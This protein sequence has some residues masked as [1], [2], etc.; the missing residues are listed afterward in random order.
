MAPHEI[1]RVDELVFEEDGINAATSAMEPHWYGG[2]VVLDIACIR[3]PV[4]AEGRSLVCQ[5][6]HKFPST[7]RVTVF[8]GHAQVICECL[9]VHPTGFLAG[10]DHLTIRSGKQGPL[11]SKFSTV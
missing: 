9:P 6:S 10:F 2:V 3:R 1:L 4:R 8:Q 7:S 11:S 5:E